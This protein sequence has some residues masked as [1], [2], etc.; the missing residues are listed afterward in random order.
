MAQTERLRVTLYGPDLQAIADD[1]GNLIDDE[2]DFVSL[3]NGGTHGPPA[4]VA[5]GRESGTPVPTRAIIGDIVM[6]INTALVPAFTAERI[7]A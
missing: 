2:V 5:P 7:K 6:Y 3:Y 1:E 4:L